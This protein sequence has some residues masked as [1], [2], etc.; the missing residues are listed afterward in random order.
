MAETVN[1]IPLNPNNFE[2]QEYSL[3]DNSL[4]TSLEIETSFNPQTDKIEYFVY[5]LNGNILYENVTGY[6]GYRL[7]DNVLTLF[8][9][10]DLTTLGFTEGQYNTLYNFV[11]PKLESNPNFT[12]FLSEISSDRTEVRLDTT[13]IPDVLVISSSIELTNDIVNTTGSYYDFYLDF[14]SNQLV[15]ANN[16]LLDTSSINNPT[17]LV[18]LYE[19]LPEQF[20]INSQLWV[21]TQVANPVAYNINIV[22][23]FELT[24][25]N[26]YLQGPNTNLSLKNQINNSTDYSNLSQLSL[27]DSTQGSGSLRYQL[28]SL[29]AKTG[30]EINID[31]SNYDN[32]IH[33]SSAQTRLENFYYK[34]SLIE[35]Y[36][37]SASLSSGTTANYYVSSSN[38][39]WQ[40]KINEIITGFDNYEYF[41][42]FDSGSASWP[43]T[44]NTPPYTN[45]SST[46]IQGQAFFVSQSAVAEEYDIENNNALINAI[47]SYL[48]EDPE[49]YQYELFIEMIGQH[50]DNIFLYTQDVT[51]KYNADNRLN[52]GV[53]KDLV[54]DILRDMGV[55]IYQNNFST[56]D[57][58]S[59]LLGLTPSGSLYNLP[60][61]TGSLPSPAG[62][63]YINT[64]ITASATG[65][66]IPTEDI[67]AEIYKRI[68]ANL[69]YL[70]K[71]KGTVEGLRALVTLY[72]IPD[73]I[74]QVNEFGGQ[75]KI[76]E[77]DYDLW[78]NQYNYAFDTLGNNYVTSSFVL[79]SAWSSQK[80]NA[81]EVRFQTRGIPSNTGYYSQSIWTTDEQT[82]LIL[83]YTG[84]A[85]TSGSYSGSI[86]NPYNEFTKLDFYPDITAPTV[87]ASVYLPFLDGGWWSVIVNRLSAEDYTLVA[88]NKNYQ[89]EDGN[90][91]GFQASSS[92]YST[93]DSWDISNKFYLGYNNGLTLGKTFS[94]SFQ[95]LRFYTTPLSQ[96]EF[97]DYVMNPY[98]IDAN[99]INTAPDTLAFRATLGGELYTSSISVHPKITGS[100]ITTQSFDGDI[101][102]FD[103]NQDF[104]IFV[105]NTE[106]FFLNQFPAGIKNRVSNKIRQQGEILPYSGSNETNLPTNQVLSPFISIQQSVAVSGS[107]TPNIDYVEVA[108]SPQNQ[109]NNDIAG[110]L[111]YFNIGEYIGDPRLVS[112]SAESYPALDGL[113]NY[114]FEKYTGNYNIWDYIRLI[115]Y[116]DNSLFKMIQD[117]TPARTDL[118]SGIVIKQTTLER[119]K[120]PVPQLDITSSLAM[121]ESGS[122]ETDVLFDL[123]NVEV[124]DV[125]FIVLPTQSY[126]LGTTFSGSFNN[127]SGDNG[128]NCYIWYYT[129][130]ALFGPP[131]ELFYQSLYTTE[132]I[133]FNFTYG[134]IVSGS[135]IEFYCDSTAESVLLNAYVTGSWLEAS[136][137]PYEVEDLL[138][139]GSS[140]QMYTITGS[141]GGSIVDTEILTF[142]T[143]SYILNSGDIVTFNI[144]SSGAERISCYISSSAENSNPAIITLYNQSTSSYTTSSV[145]LNYT[146]NQTF[147]ISTGYLRIQNNSLDAA[148]KI[149][150]LEVYQAPSYY[151]T[152]ET[153]YGLNQVLIP[154]E[155]DFNGELEGSEILVT[156]GD[157]NPSNPYK[158]PSTQVILFDVDTVMNTSSFPVVANKITL[159][160]STEAIDASIIYYLTIPNQ[161]KNSV[162]ITSALDNLTTG[163]RIQ[164]TAVGDIVGGFTYN[165]N[166]QIKTIKNIVGGVFI[167][168]VGS[169]PYDPLAQGN[170]TATNAETIFTPFL[171]EPN[172]YTSAFNPITNNA[173]IARL[174]P[175]FFD[176]DFST[177]AITAVNRVNIISASRGTGSATPAAVQASNYTT[178]RIINPRYVGSKNTSPDFN[179]ITNQQL[180]SVEKYTSYFIYTPGGFGRTLAERSGSANYKIG[181]LVDELGNIIQ[182]IANNTSSAYIPNLIDAFG[183]DTPVILSPTNNTTI[184]KAEFTVYKPAVISNV[185]MYSDTGSLGTGTLVSGSYNSINF[186]VDPNIKFNY[187]LTIVKSGSA[188]VQTVSSGISV[189]ASFNLITQD[190]AQGWTSSINAYKP[191]YTSLIRNVM[192]ASL[193]LDAPGTGG[194]TMSIMDGNTALVTSSAAGPNST[195]NLTALTIQYFNTS[196]L[197]WVKITNNTNANLT[198][199]ITTSPVVS[200]LVISSQTSSI[201]AN[202]PYWAT[203]SAGNL[204]LTSS[205]D[206]GKAYQYY[207]QVPVTASGSPLTSSGF[208][209]PE[210]LSILPYDEIRFDGNE[211]T[212]ATILS[213]SFDGSNA[214]EPVL[215]LHL[216]APFA[217]DSVDIQYFAIRRWVSSVDNLIINS[218][219][220][221]VGPGFIFPK[222]PSPL[223]K[224]N[225]PTI[226]ENLTN[227]GLIST[228]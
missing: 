16:I 163:N 111:G 192:F 162:D 48:L 148:I 211:A 132:E 140:I 155:F 134:P 153:V 204:V 165:F 100:W 199:K 217:F 188:S 23:T 161:S 226:I 9:D 185:I 150:N 208:D 170:P 184:E 159:Y 32:F 11:S 114:Y 198:V 225:L 179:I 178:A 223:L 177:N 139:T 154:N 81:V 171:N 123:T 20:T 71:K 85:Y 106:S 26:I 65:S 205:F 180:P 157:L 41:L 12:Y 77:N 54:A 47:P 201:Q 73:T 129:P 37:Y 117:F 15:I 98:S 220:T 137:V 49:N 7:L 87:T 222:Y 70:L 28:N 91:I 125:N 141:S 35:Q 3:E 97:A 209:N 120:Y 94:G 151:Q 52:Y 218:P 116:F 90:Y 105:P 109:I 221:L 136:N 19:P 45:Y 147:D 172:F 191:P 227:K 101:S 144:S 33:F 189:T 193:A 5:D 75:N 80:P 126:N 203:G 214:I 46:S 190:A 4:I 69:P 224:Q 2:F 53:S 127:V 202:K 42:Y 34:L 194:V 51:N 1:I 27:T 39:I 62:Y 40:S 183:A 24:D 96:S 121:V 25:E 187:N 135:K 58:Y 119:N 130:D 82:A 149:S 60:Y 216:Q 67:N 138:I 195:M 44:G 61:T 143:A 31:Y 196:S 142:S 197:Y 210:P 95:E 21:V 55:K 17:V 14:G 63:E 88:A 86:P 133:D 219:S 228:T 43:K 64:Y 131:I 79:N 59:A 145:K 212:V 173:D 110:Q 56:N 115:K 182:P 22:Q 6:T 107:Y 158:H 174:D 99:G 156:D 76:I 66:L 13:N 108:F 168:I 128:S 78:F 104:T 181:F 122:Y 74:L 8:P 89:G 30:I 72:G 206:I 166:F 200:G 29:L 18:K 10:V 83:K 38:V 84:S 213:S 68:Y 169:Y 57:L 118:A 176:V 215:Y 207:A 160:G 152:V 103:F 167:E 50:F 175:E 92:V 113:R 93:T 186:H 164:F 102:T 36:N 124:A 112:S 146:L